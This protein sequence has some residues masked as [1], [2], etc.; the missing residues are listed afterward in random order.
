MRT[1][2]QRPVIKLNSTA[3]P[4]DEDSSSLEWTNASCCLPKQRCTSRAAWVPIKSPAVPIVEIYGLNVALG[5][6]NFLKESLRACELYPSG[7]VDMCP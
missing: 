1:W 3:D 7:R 2:V 6:T 4:D 5:N